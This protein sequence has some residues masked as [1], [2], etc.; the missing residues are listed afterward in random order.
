MDR[1]MVLK[2]ILNKEGGSGLDSYGS[3]QRPVVCSCEYGNG[4]SMNACFPSQCHNIQL[5]KFAHHF[6]S[7][8]YHSHSQGY[9]VLH[10]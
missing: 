8:T 9:G 5:L 2:W 10:I 3:G 4:L 7:Q 1:R 6:I